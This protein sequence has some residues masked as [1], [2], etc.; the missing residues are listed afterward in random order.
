[1]WVLNM[2]WKCNLKKTYKKKTYL[3]KLYF[4]FYILIDFQFTSEGELKSDNKSVSYFIL[5]NPY[6]NAFIVFLGK[7]DYI[8]PQTEIEMVCTGLYVNLTETNLLTIKVNMTEIV[9]I[10]ASQ[11]NY[12]L[13]MQN[14]LKYEFLITFL[15]DVSIFYYY[16]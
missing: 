6:F 16:F 15:S 4:T 9:N 7:K 13:K 12:T 3:K 2:L 14:T 1:M 10:I 11:Y 8:L 5:W